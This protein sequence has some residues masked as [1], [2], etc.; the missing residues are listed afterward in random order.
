MVVYLQRTCLCFLVSRIGVRVTA[1]NAV[2]Q[3]FGMLT[4][5]A[6]NMRNTELKYTTGSSGSEL[7]RHYFIE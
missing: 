3:E 4:S 6:G 7:W 1:V 2:G 5:V